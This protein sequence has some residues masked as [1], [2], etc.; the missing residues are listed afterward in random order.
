[1]KRILCL[2]LSLLMLMSVAPMVANAADVYVFASGS[3]GEN[4]EWKLYSDGTLAIS[5]SGDMLYEPYNTR[6]WKHYY[7][8]IKKVEIKNGITSL[9]KDAFTAC[10]FTEISI[11]DSVI[12]IDEEAFQNCSKLPSITL[13]NGIKAIKDGTFEGCSALK[14]IIIPDGTEYIGS[15]AFSGCY[16][17]SEIS[18]P[19][20]VSGI[21]EYAFSFCN[22]LSKIT[23]LNSDC[24]IFDSASTIKASAVI[25]GYTN[26]TAHI[27]AEKYA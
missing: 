3:K 10:Y 18:I 15:F 20:S 9:C 14:S 2:V 5:G 1:M 27:Y 16:A 11:P 19:E 21:G 13:P 8:V 6:D 17:L 26:S 7:D 22:S 25:Y 23:V 12:S 24:D 4:L